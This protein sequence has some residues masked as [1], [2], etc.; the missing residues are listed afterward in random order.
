MKY[1][2]EL[3]KCSIGRVYVYNL[4][5]SNLVFVDSLMF[6][7]VGGRSLFWKFFEVVYV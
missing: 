2:M 6:H 4:V 3:A 5:T 1:N 7:I